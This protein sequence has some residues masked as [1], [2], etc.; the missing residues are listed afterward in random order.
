MT[1]PIQSSAKFAHLILLSASL[2]F[3][4]ISFAGADVSCYPTTDMQHNAYTACDNLPALTPAND[5]Q[6]NMLLLLSDL[7]LAKLKFDTA[8]KSSL[9]ETQYS[10]VPFET[11]SLT[12]AAANK[13][14]N[15][16]LKNSS[17]ADP[18]QEHCSSLKSGANAFS[19]HVR[20]DSQLSAREKDALLKERAKLTSCQNEISL[21]AVNP[22]DSIRARQYASYLNGAIAFYNSH[23]STAAKIFSALTAA[24]QPWIKETSQYML[25]RSNLNA[26]FQ[27]GVG[28]YGDLDHDKLDQKLLLSFFNSITAYF[29]QYPNGQYAA[30]ARGMLRRG[31]WLSGQQDRLVDELAWQI[32]HPES[33]VYN[34]ELNNLVYEIDRHVFQSRS[35]KAQNL[36][37]PS[38]LAI[39]DL[40]LMRKAE[41]PE[42]KVISWAELNSQKALFKN[43]PELFQYL[44]AN[45]L[46]FVQNKAQD[47][48]SYLPKDLSAADTSASNYLSLSQI[49]LKGRI[50]EK[51]QG[52]S[53][54]TQQYWESG[55]NKAKTPEQ[56]GL[57]ELMLYPY[58]AKQQAAEFFSGSKAKIQQASL[59]KAFIDEHANEHSLMQIVQDK[60]ASTDQKNLALFN[61]LQKSLIHQNFSLFNQ[62]YALLPK[63]A[64]QYVYNS[65]EKFENFQ[66]QPP[67]GNFVWKGHT[68]SSSIQCPELNS[69]MQKLQQNPQ[70][71]TLRLCLGEYVRSEQGYRVNSQTYAEKQRS[72]FYGPIFA[73]GQVYKDILKTSGNSELKAYA[74][75]RSIM[76]YSPGG[77]ND[78]QDSDVAK[79]VRKQWYDQIKRD[80]PNTVWAKS[81]K[82]YW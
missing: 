3:S 74:L 2:F 15:A 70:D 41:S 80:Y 5:N 53:D 1:I 19:A 22:N 55:L 81:L 42:D 16:R 31:F 79:P 44:Q 23:F 61:L 54:Q 34:L 52:A 24:D 29:K 8:E 11:K 71:L 75:Y 6:T 49:L 63:N 76:C 62:A 32:N 9:W 27:S 64:A 36:K 46:F 57:F 26:A 20:A 28:E 47:A 10:V 50:L 65:D 78:C 21:L 4:S 30:S 77:S 67:L 43:R 82:Y 7:G 12:Y 40:M 60:S 37:D 35:F 14:P 73:R 45:H 48:L 39:Y 58:Y 66:H 38:F 68:V 51:L 25:I 13:A 33:K 72:Y 56:R 18:Y 69:L 59:Q 17:E